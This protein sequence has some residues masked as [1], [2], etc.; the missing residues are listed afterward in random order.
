LPHTEP[1]AGLWW[2]TLLACLATPLLQA[3]TFTAGI[4]LLLDPTHNI[5]VLLGATPGVAS[6]DSFNLFIVMCLLWLTVRIPRLMARYVTHGRSSISMAG[7]VLR[8]VVI[9]SVTR[10]LPVPA[11]R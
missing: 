3:I 1:A 9:Q 4:S 10:R 5:P 11:R 8:A 7:V 6:M 2:R